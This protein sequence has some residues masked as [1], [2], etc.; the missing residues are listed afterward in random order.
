M[1]K[2]HGFDH[3]KFDAQF[4]KTEKSVRRFM[5]FAIVAWIIG[6]IISLA[7]LIGIVYVAIHFLQKVW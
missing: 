5:G 1:R 2:S 6:A 4:T 7:L 3:D